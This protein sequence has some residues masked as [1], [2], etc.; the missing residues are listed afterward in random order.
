MNRTL[1]FVL[2]KMLKNISLKDPNAERANYYTTS[3]FV[4][5]FNGFLNKVI[6]IIQNHFQKHCKLDLV[7]S[8]H[9]LMTRPLLFNFC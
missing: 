2:V 3:T 1:D 6:K 7:K 8:E 5:Y 9:E 4:I